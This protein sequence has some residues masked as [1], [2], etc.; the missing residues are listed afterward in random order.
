MDDN[1]EIYYI[2]VS[3]HRDL[4]KEEMENY[5]RQI[6]DVLKKIKAKEP[7]K[8]WRVL[9]PLADGADRLAVSAAKDLGIEYEVLLPMDRSLYE[10]DF[11]ARSLS[12]F[13][14]LLS[15]ALSVH[16][17]PLCEGCTDNNIADYG[18]WRDR[19]YQKMGY[20]LVDRVDRMLFLWDGKRKWVTGGTYDV[21]RYALLRSKPFEIIPVRRS[22]KDDSFIVR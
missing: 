20:A 16:I 4:K 19:Q 12:E 1:N 10:R 18:E 13:R 8:V 5:R 2:G 11:D 7:T 9:S 21:L 3:G 17:A 14:S 15:E 22:R 6:V